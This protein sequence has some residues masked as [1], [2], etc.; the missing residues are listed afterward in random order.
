MGFDWIAESL[1]LSIFSSDIVQLT[2]DDWKKIT[3]EDSP[4]AEQK[5]VGRHTMSGPFLGGQLNLLAS[6]GSRFDCILT[7]PPPPEPSP[8]EYVP[9]IGHWPEVRKEFLAATEGW[10]AG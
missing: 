10:V 2:S 8:E 6:G 5:V 3:G 4:K 7:A 9:R 1:R